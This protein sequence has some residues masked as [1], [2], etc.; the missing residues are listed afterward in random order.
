MKSMMIKTYLILTILYI[1]GLVS[2]MYSN[3]TA[4]TF[5]FNILIVILIRF[6]PGF[7]SGMILNYEGI[8]KFLKSNPRKI[9]YRFILFSIFLI[10]LASYPAWIYFIPLNPNTFPDY[11]L[12]A[13]F[14][15]QYTIGIL[16][17][18]SITQSPLMQA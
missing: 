14:G 6:F 3:Y 11:T 7:L 13:S 17:G 12:I 16:S 18:Y 2:Q 4:S 15:F 5:K 9:D 8:S 1:T 10:I